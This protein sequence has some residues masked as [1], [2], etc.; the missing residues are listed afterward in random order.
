MRA[1]VSQISA[2]QAAQRFRGLTSSPCPDI[3]ATHVPRSSHPTVLRCWLC[4]WL[5]SVRGRT[6]PRAIGLHTRPDVVAQRSSRLTGTWRGCCILAGP[7]LSSS[8]LSGEGLA[9]KHAT[10]EGDELS[11]RHFQSACLAGGDQRRWPL[12]AV[13]ARVASVGS[14]SLPLAAVW[15][16][17]VPLAA[18]WPTFLPRVDV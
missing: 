13:E 8:V 18:V 3:H 16:D 4:E 2:G 1:R 12:R 15:L 7:W 9:A 5:A 6:N 11:M 17:E 10:L 14:S